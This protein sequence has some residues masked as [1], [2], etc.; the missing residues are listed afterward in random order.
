M[1]ESNTERLKRWLAT[2]EAAL[3]PATFPQLELWDASPVPPG[4]AANNICT[5]TKITGAV[6]RDLAE[7]A[8]KMV[9]ARQD[10]L[11][12]SILPGKAG[13]LQ[14]IRKHREPALTIHPYRDLSPEELEEFID[15]LIEKPFDLVGGPLY[16]VDVVRPRPGLHVLVLVIHHAIGDGW[17]LGSF[18]SDLWTSFAMLTLA[19]PNAALGY[20]ALFSIR[21][22]KTQ[23]AAVPRFSALS[24]PHSR[25]S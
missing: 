15:S 10:V 20:P 2:G 3:Y 6:S 24:L 13:P 22:A 1:A 19:V 8:L 14:L 4:H 11:R 9:V 18:M 16:R 25:S 23:P 7:T 21:F 12:L 17:S 5:V